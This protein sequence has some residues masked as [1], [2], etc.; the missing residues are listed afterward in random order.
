[1]SSLNGEGYIKLALEDLSNTLASKNRDYRIDGEFSN[2]EAAASTVTS[3]TGLALTAEEVIAAQIGIK[4]GRLQGLPLDPSNESRLDT[5][6]DLA[7]YAIILYAYT[8]KEAGK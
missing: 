2:F 7:G 8:L 1:M 5:V 4:I 3:L 6:K